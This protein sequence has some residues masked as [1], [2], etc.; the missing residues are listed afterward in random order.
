MRFT[1][2]RFLLG[3][4]FAS[5]LAGCGGIGGGE[6]ES[7]NLPPIIAGTP[8]TQLTSGTPYDFQ[9][10][11][12][13]PDGDAL[14]FTATNL[15]AWASINTQTGRV[16][17]TPG[18]AD[19]GISNQIEISVSDQ[20]SQ[21]SLPA[22]QIRVMA[23][24]TPPVQ[25]NTPPT[26]EG[27][28]GT[29]ATV[30]QQYTFVPVGNDVDGNSLTY[31][32]VNKPSWATF[33]SG[34]GQLS[35]TPGAGDVGTTSNIVISVYDG[36]ATD[37]LPSFNLQ[38]VATAPVNRAPSI[39]GSPATTVTAGS[40]YVFRPVASD[41]DGNSLRFSIQ[42]QPAWATFSTSSGRLSGTPTSANVGTSGR[43]TISVTDGTETVSLP[44]F[45]I[46]VIAAANRAPTIGGTP[47][48]TVTA[49]QGYTFQPTA[50]DAD[51]DT[52]TF[53]IQNRPTWATFNTATGV[54]TGTPSAADVASYPNVIIS[55]SDGKASTSLPAF[56]VAVVQA[57]N[58]T[59]TLTW[60]APTTNTDGTA[61]TNLSGYRLE[62][63]QSQGSPS[64]SVEINSA[65]ITT[66]TVTNLASG[67]WYF[68]VY[69]ITSAG[70]ESSPSNTAS[71]TIN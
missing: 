49:E 66:Y 19:V 59:A 34:S 15:P 25:I 58:G 70:G 67:T 2:V 14:S 22:F 40:A 8:T 71:K 52:L 26:I 62:Y 29:T 37:S 21:V 38:V 41:P 31:T 18:G 20:K 63:G 43:I 68:A 3:V 24:E 32:I 36:G 50:A 48:S 12:A 61:L 9:P 54:L 69:A 39:T 60:D 1:V 42:G 44:A 13:D 10:T 28:P 56:S 47:P 5:A 6:D 11:A 45:T 30:G 51:G 23:V 55:V 4:A 7:N 64:Q 17:G 27:N 53:S 16:T 57:A 35:G 46:Q 65:G 33:S